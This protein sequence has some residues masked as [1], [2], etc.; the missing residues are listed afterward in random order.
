MAYLGYIIS[1]E[2]VE[3]DPTKMEAVKNWPSLLTQID[4]R[5]FLGLEGYFR[6]FMDGF[7]SIAA[8][9]NT[10]TQKCKKFEW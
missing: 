1:S 3:V 8:P 9:S 6:R 2:G 7:A 4:I 5:S 10:L